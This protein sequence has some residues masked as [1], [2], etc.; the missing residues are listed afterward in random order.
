[1]TAFNIVKNPSFVLSVI[2]SPRSPQ[3]SFDKFSWLKHAI[4]Q[5]GEAVSDSIALIVMLASRCKHEDPVTYLRKS[6]TS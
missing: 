6:F 5:I 2:P 4:A 1:M 3:Y